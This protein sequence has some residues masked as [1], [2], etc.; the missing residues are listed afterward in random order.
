M[1]EVDHSLDS[2]EQAHFLQLPQS[3]F[4][5]QHIEYMDTGFKI[6]IMLT[7][8]I[9]IIW[10]SSIIDLFLFIFAF[11]AFIPS[12]TYATPIFFFIV[13]VF[14]AV[15]GIVATIKIPKSSKIIDEVS[16]NLNSEKDQPVTLEKFPDY[17]LQAT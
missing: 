8:F 12:T 7:D 9:N 2:L 11:G 3:E 17:M 15:C 10:W 16:Q 13:H 14:R 4:A 6:Q 1:H 5:M